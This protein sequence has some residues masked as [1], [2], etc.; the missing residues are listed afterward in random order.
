MKTSGGYRSLKYFASIVIL[1]A[2]S[3]FFVPRVSAQ[4]STPSGNMQTTVEATVGEFTLT[5]SGFISPNASIVMTD[6][7]GITISSTVADSLGNFSFPIL[8]IKRGFSGFC[9]IANDFNRLGESTTCFSFAPVTESIVMTNIF[10]PPTLGLSRTEIGVGGSAL[11]FGYTM[12]GA[13]VTLHIAGGSVLTVTADSTGHYEFTIENLPVGSYNLFS[14]GK[15][16][17]IDSN[18]P[19]KTVLLKVLS[20]EQQAVGGF[21]K[22]IGNLWDKLKHF[23]LSV[24]LIIL[25]GIPIIILI[26]ILLRKLHPDWIR[27]SNVG[28]KENKKSLHHWWFV[29]Y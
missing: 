24:P 2:I 22:F 16:N 23:L 18:Q 29:G 15:Y 20:Q 9:L 6:S 14:T 5:V 25:I 7:N 3:I 12:S 10:L 19:T 26:I 1:L 27:F 28:K 17:G 13:T 21:G 11:A 8:P 4:V